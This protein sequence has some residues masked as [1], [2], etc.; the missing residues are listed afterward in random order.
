MPPFKVGDE[1]IVVGVPGEAASWLY[2]DR[3]GTVQ[4]VYEGKPYPNEVQLRHGGALCFTDA[5]LTHTAESSPGRRLLN[6][7]SGLA[8]GVDPFKAQ[9]VMKKA[10]SKPKPPSSSVLSPTHYTSHPSGIECIQITKHLNFPVG[11]AIK[12]LWRADLKGDA[13]EDLEKARTYIDIEIE[14]RREA[15]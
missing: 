8:M 10:F 6:E 14:R 4:A 3:R 11:N 2:E 15:A 13:V 12:Y 9:E 5:E 1:V 7:T